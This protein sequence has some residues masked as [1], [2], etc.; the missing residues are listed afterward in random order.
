MSGQIALSSLRGAASSNRAQGRTVV[1]PPPSSHR[2]SIEH[3]E[4]ANSYRGEAAEAAGVTR[5]EAAANQRRSVVNTSNSPP[6]AA[7]RNKYSAKVVPEEYNTTNL[8][9]KVHSVVSDISTKAFDSA[10]PINDLFADMDGPMMPS[11]PSKKKKKNKKKKVSP[12]F[13]A[14]TCT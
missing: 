3:R 14:R 2:I 4:T 8:T 6:P 1:L 10:L 5:Q 9:S 7:G 13:S 12:D 11:S